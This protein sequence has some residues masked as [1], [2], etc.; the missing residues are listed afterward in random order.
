MPADEA[1]ECLAALL[2]EGGW[3][4]R[5]LAR[6]LNATF[7]QG[8]VSATAPYFWRDNGSVPHAPLPAMVA[9][10][11]SDRLGRRVTAGDIWGRQAADSPNLQLA[12]AGMNH[13]WSVAGTR[14][15]A[16]DWLMGGLVDR[17]HFL[18]VSGT[19]LA[20]AVSAYLAAE[21]P[22]SAVAPAVL[23]GRD[24]LVEQIEAS[25]PLLQQLDDAKGGA[26]NLGYI[27]AQLRAVALVLHEGTYTVAETRRLLAALADLGQLAG[28]MAFDANQ[29][30]LAQRY[31]FTGLRAA[32]D[33]GYTAMAAHILADLSFQAATNGNRSDGV[34]LG[35][36]ARR[37]AARVPTG[38]RAS[39]GSRLAY[40][41]AAG[42]HITEFEYI[43]ADAADTLAGRDPAE[44]P[45]WLYYLT[46]GH[47]DSQAGYALVLAGRERLADGDRAG[48]SLLRRG[49]A[50]LRAGAHDLPPGE[51]SQR[52]AL[53]EGAWLALGYAARGDL[54]GACGEAR[55]AIG[56]LCS[57]RSP[58]SNTLLH[59]LS[60]DLRRRTRNP[61][62]ASLLPDLD[63][64]LATQPQAPGIS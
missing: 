25:I 14:M 2:A 43:Y 63:Q 21:A 6:A 60:A 52:R 12:S 32:H 46:P 50:L 64:A 42:G 9:Y 19:A 55:T 28:W 4:P 58:R 49:T 54:E 38:V 16:R 44:D 29:H 22:A 31:F 47:L 59:R 41:Y 13:P 61:H 39:V 34:T 7:G 15:V 48:R 57:V 36:A 20:G 3:T 18:A 37:H 10:A 51:P 1:N 35:E 56:R 8:T 17:R 26:A 45:P 33:A 24:L 27:G 62:V 40:A 30:G 53:Y 5:A 11:L 23:G